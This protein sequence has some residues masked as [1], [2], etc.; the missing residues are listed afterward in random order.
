MYIFL[1][2]TKKFFKNSL[3]DHYQHFKR[4]SKVTNDDSGLLLILIA[5]YLPHSTH[6]LLFIV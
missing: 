5:L 2:I 6:R 4:S 3:K 1:N